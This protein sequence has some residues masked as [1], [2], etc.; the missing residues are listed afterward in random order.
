[1]SP[2]TSRRPE[3]LRGFAARLR[4]LVGAHRDAPWAVREP[5]LQPASARNRL[6][7][8]RLAARFPRF[9]KAIAVRRVY[10]AFGRT[11]RLSR[12]AARLAGWEARSASQPHGA[13][14]QPRG[15]LVAAPTPVEVIVAVSSVCQL[16]C[17]MCG[18]HDVMQLPRFRGARLS[19]ADLAGPIR[20]LSEWRPR[21]YVK[22]TGGEPLLIGEE[23]FRML[24]D[25]RAKKIP[26]RVST[27]GI[28]LADRAVAAELART[29]VDV[30]T[31]SL[32]GPR[33]VHNAIRGR[34][35]AFDRTLAGI[36]NLAEA[37]S[38]QRRVSPLI[39]VSSVLHAANASHLREIFQLCCELPIDWWNVQLLNF[40]R[41]AA[42][43][44]ADRVAREWGNEPGPWRSFIHE[45]LRLVDADALASAVTWIKR[46]NA[47]FAVSFHGVGGF[48]ADRLRAYYGDGDAALGK[49][50][51]ALPFMSMNVAPTGD[52]IFC[53][54]YP[55][56]TYG[57]IRDGSL[58]ASWNSVAARR[59]RANYLRVRRQTGRPLP[60][61]SRC[62]WL[63]N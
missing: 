2:P 38:A 16:S 57:N 58:K 37:R 4:G 32:D 61:C 44:A 10:E 12:L 31:V 23:L 18:I 54:D 53:I 21:P 49:R 51:C 7:I 5:P 36:R 25:C 48:D 14:A 42:A 50:T 6:R 43:E 33:D 27:N 34:D 62:N 11:G 28:L 46:R 35:F 17:R 20:E 55:Y 24:A 63:Y 52:M 60:Q 26:T 39:Q 22:F 40:V 59:F 29:G 19:Y 41:P 1:M 8:A 13:A 30:V 9:A 56:V 3:R 15:E 45:D 47:P